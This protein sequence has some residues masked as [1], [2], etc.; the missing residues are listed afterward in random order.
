M[1]NC[2][3]KTRH[4]CAKGMNYNKVF[5]GWINLEILNGFHSK[6]KL[7]RFLWTVVVLYNLNINH[8]KISNNIYESNFMRYKTITKVL[9]SP[10]LFTEENNLQKHLKH[11]HETNL[12]NF[13]KIFD[14][15]SVNEF[16][17][18]WGFLTSSSIIIVLRTQIYEASQKNRPIKNLCWY[19]SCRALLLWEIIISGVVGCGENTIYLP[20]ETN[21]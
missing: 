14:K 6:L 3:K 19:A 8:V 1:K 18:Y 2:F 5:N 4:L 16:D 17:I 10:I 21:P 20:Q 7:N 9:W 13:Y 11:F 12:I 15:A